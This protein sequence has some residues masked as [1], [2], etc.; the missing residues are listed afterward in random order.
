MQMT[1][2]RRLLV[3]MFQRVMRA[4]AGVFLLSCY[5]PVVAAE[6][7]GLESDR[8]IATVR[9]GSDA[10]RDVERKLGPAPCLVPS[11]SGD[12]VSYL[13]NVQNAAGHAFLRL[14]VN[15]QVDAIT[16][17]KDPPLA[18]VC[19]APVQKAVV[20]RTNSGLEL[21]ATMEEVIRLYGKPSE[22]FSVGSMAR[23]RYLA[24]LDRPYEWDLVFRDGRLV[25]WT[26]VTEE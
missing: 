4:A 13:Y 14:E 12:T 19:Y 2:D 26:V 3:P 21:G 23:F 15:G 24:M 8:G 5:A 25:E 11:I 10:A 17:S 7:G 18:G 6:P 20:L 9:V 1:D 22:R 16:I